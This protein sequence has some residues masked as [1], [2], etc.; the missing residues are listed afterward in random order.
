MTLTYLTFLTPDLTASF[1]AKSIA[2]AAKSV[3]G[4]T[5]KQDVDPTTDRDTY[6]KTLLQAGQ[7]SGLSSPLGVKSVAS[8]NA[9]YAGMMRSLAGLL[10]T[11]GRADAAAAADAKLT[12]WP[13][14]SSGC[15]CPPGAGRSGIPARLSPSVTAWT[16][17]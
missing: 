4:V 11:L 3:P 6:A 16:S 15:R 5:I 14:R 7:F 17:G 13:G 12:R 9:A 10:R 8:L 2:A 1:W